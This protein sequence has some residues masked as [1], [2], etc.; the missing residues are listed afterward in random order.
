VSAEASTDAQR[1]ALGEIVNIGMGQAGDKL[2][3][4]LETFIQLSVPR[5]RLIEPAGVMEAIRALVPSDAPIIAVRQ[6]FS[7]QMRGEAIV[8]FD[9]AGCRGLRDLMHYDGGDADELV[10][11]VSNLLV[12]AC[13]NGIALQISQELSFS[14]P[15]LLGGAE[16]LDQ[17]LG[18]TGKPWQT[19]L[20]AEV[21]FRIESQPFQAH[22]LMFWPDDAIQTLHRAVDD[23]LASLT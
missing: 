16:A 20:I 11:E 18:A 1:D 5:V 17:A 8:V 23:L 22:L 21:N 3:R 19:A 4:L 14:P 2:A 15:S 12:G 13:L 9:A 7:S 6:A 10:L